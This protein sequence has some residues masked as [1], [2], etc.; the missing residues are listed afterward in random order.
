MKLSKDERKQLDT[1]F[2]D[3][4]RPGMILWMEP[5]NGDTYAKGFCQCDPVD[6]MAMASFAVE[7]FAACYGLEPKVAAQGL[8]KM[9]ESDDYKSSDIDGEIRMF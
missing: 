9:F 5:R 2:A 3:Q 6:V 4:K 8:V 7:I 1:L